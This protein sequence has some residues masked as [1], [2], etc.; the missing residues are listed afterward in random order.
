MMQMQMY[1]DTFIEIAKDL[2][3]KYGAEYAGEKRLTFVFQGD[4]H[5]AIFL[6]D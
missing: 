5:W 1:V 6:D 4:G 2:V 3:K